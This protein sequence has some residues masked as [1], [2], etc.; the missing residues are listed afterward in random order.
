M[1]AG[2]E[3]Q[4]RDC[5]NYAKTQGWKVD[6]VFIDNDLSASRYSKKARVGFRQMLEW[7]NAAG[8]AALVVWSLDRLSRQPKELEALIDV[9]E[10]GVEVH[11]VQGHL[12]LT[13]AEGRLFARNLMAHAA[14]ESDM[15]SKRIRRQKL[16]RAE[17]GL[18]HGGRRAF[19]FEP[20]GK[21]VVPAEAKLIREMARRVLADQSLNSVARW[22]S[23][24]GAASP[25]GGKSWSGTTVGVILRN[26]RIAGLRARRGEVVGEAV[27]K[28]IVD[29]L[30]WRRL[31]RYFGDPARRQEP[32]RRSLFT[33]LVQCGRCGGVLSRRSRSGLPVWVCQRAPGRSNCGGLYV[34]ANPLEELVV[35]A[36]LTAA[37]GKALARRVDKRSKRGSDVEANA[38][39]ELE[40]AEEEL[41]LLAEMLGAGELS[42]REWMAAREPLQ[43]RVAAAEAQ[44]V[45]V[46]SAV[47]VK[48]YAR[49]G[50]LRSAWS[51]QMTLDQRRA[52]LKA[53]IEKVVVNPTQRRGPRFDHDRVKVAWR[54]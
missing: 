36:M 42:H 22:L 51:G 23:D 24:I 47:A 13:T 16:A 10:G 31:S 2:I 4:R 48:A 15:A 21:T 27:W 38:S 37:D 32:K 19:G 34:S 29:E 12:N 8:G 17:Q 7:A 39:K 14:A 45:E 28:P 33:G 49:P 25:Q 11:T 3:R 30:T 44:L 52:V 50:A 6:E 53:V 46:T 40:R 43:Q 5:L 41:A 9:A 26:P 54:A 1:G 18:P 35:E 20:D